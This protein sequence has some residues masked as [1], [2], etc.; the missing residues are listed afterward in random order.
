MKTNIT[1]EDRS[2]RNI[3]SE[4]VDFQWIIEKLCADES[5]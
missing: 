2:R 5:C 1:N 3:E 4:E